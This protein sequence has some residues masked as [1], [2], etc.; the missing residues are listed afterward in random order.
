M[1]R[2]TPL[3]IALYVPVT[4]CIADDVEVRR[5]FP[6][7]L[8]ALQTA[9]GGYIEPVRLHRGALAALAGYFD[10][11]LGDPV[12]LVDE[13]GLLKQRPANLFASAIAARPIVGDVLIVDIRD[14]DEGGAS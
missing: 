5:D 14:P 1:S 3:R 7:S 10:E 9:V 13:E 11:D 2:P 4:A 6:I 12:M 8:K